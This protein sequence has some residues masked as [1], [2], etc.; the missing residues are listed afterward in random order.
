MTSHTSKGL[1]MCYI[2]GISQISLKTNTEQCESY[3]LSSTAQSRI[4]LNYING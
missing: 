4:V 3:T 1:F 2:I